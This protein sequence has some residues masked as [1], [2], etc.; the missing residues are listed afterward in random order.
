M[1]K[2]DREHFGSRF[3]VIMA[4]AGA[5]IGLGNIWRFPYMVGEHGGSAFILVYI[6]A[7]AFISLPIF[8]SELMIG[9]RSRVSAFGAMSK[10]APGSKFWKAAGFLPVLIPVII[11]SYYSVVGGWALE[12]L[13]KSCQ[14]VFVHSSPLESAEIFNDYISSTWTPLVTAGIF[15]GLTGVI[16]A[17]GVRSG[18][19]KFSK[20]TMPVLFILILVIL[21]YSCC[22]PG[23]GQGIKY[24]VKPDFSQLT[25]QTFA[26]ALGQSFYS[27]SLGMG[28]I[29]TYGSYVSSKENVLVSGV[30]TAVSDLVFAV[31]A[32]FAIMPAVFAAGIE[33]GAGA[34][35]IFKTI[36]FVF[37]KMAIQMPVVSAVISILFFLTIVVAA[38][39]SNM[40]MYEVVVAYLLEKFGI[41]RGLGSV[42]VFVICGGLGIFSSLSFGQLA[43]V[44]VFGKS[45]FGFFDWLSSN[46]LLLFSGFLS[47]VF[48][49]WVMKEEDLW[50]EFTNEGEKKVNYR[51]FRPV[52]FL[53]RWV[54]PVAVVIIFIANFIL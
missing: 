15:L 34:G 7:T 46:I 8:F 39:T 51:W 10:L 13:F 26:Y 44:T 54:A 38:I 27:M 25:P 28:A 5:A 29:I 45:L 52:R 43:D 1:V 11:T 49:G 42:I 9:R 32:G 48:A 47:V 21:V 24:L 37:S 12:Y 20:Y 53:M 4:M 16:I 50:N 40:C 2:K 14:M 23:A 41:R 30:G 35:L 36:P 17:G 6:I 3:A 22:L 31:L 33:P 18:I 19:E